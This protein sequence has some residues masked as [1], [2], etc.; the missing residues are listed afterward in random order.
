MDNDHILLFVHG[1]TGDK[2]IY[3]EVVRY[4]PKKFDVILIDLPGHGNSKPDD[5]ESDYRPSALVDSVHQVNR[6]SWSGYYRMRK[7]I[8]NHIVQ[9][10][11]CTFFF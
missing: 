10:N 9:P 2:G 5:E 11:Q 6:D 1:F 7:Y 4:L 8:T 3:C